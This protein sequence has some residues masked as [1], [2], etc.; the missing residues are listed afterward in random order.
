MQREEMAQEGHRRGNAHHGLT[1]EGEYGEKGDR[2]GVE[3]QHVDLIMLEHRVEEG[4]EGRNQASPEGIYEDW[5]LGG[6]PSHASA[7]RRPSHRLS[8]LIET[9]GE[10]GTHLAHGLIVE[11][12]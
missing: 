3:M 12:Q 11:H 2:L 6:C 10:H 5:D 1:D 7:R 4:G 9:G 8:P